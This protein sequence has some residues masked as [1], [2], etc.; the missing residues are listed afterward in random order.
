MAAEGLMPQGTPP[1]VSAICSKVPGTA[2]K[3]GSR[4]NKPNAATLLVVPTKTLPLAM[5]GGT[6]LLP[7]P[8]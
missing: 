6:N 3:L 7:E 4:F 8:K 2:L 1:E 5:A